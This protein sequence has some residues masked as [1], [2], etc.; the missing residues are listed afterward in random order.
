MKE[1]NQPKKMIHPPTPL[2]SPSASGLNV[3]SRLRPLAT[4]T[5]VMKTKPTSSTKDRI[6]LQEV[7]QVVADDGHA[8]LDAA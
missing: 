1:K 5:T 4:D 7:D 2:S 6:R 8:K 3:E